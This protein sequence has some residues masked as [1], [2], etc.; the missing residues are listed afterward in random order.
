MGNDKQAVEW[1]EKAK[2]Q[3]FDRATDYLTQR[4][5]RKAFEKLIE[6]QQKEFEAKI[7]EQLEQFKADKLKLVAE[8]KKELEKQA[9]FSSLIFTSVSLGITF[10]FL[11]IIFSYVTSRSDGLE[12][13]LQAQFEAQKTVVEMQLKQYEEKAS[14]P[15]PAIPSPKKR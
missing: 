1:L 11:G 8:A 2:E 6:D 7:Q 4:T 3:K 12:N 9:Q 15:L 10:T 14:P 13:K 5:A